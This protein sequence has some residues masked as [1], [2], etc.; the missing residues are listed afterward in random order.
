[1]A[2]NS[3][4]NVFKGI[5]SDREISNE[6]PNGLFGTNVYKTLESCWWSLLTIIQWTNTTP[7]ISRYFFTVFI[8]GYFIFSAPNHFIVSYVKSLRLYPLLILKRILFSIWFTYIFI[9]GLLIFYLCIYKC[10]QN[11]LEYLIQNMI[12]LVVQ[13]YHYLLEKI[14]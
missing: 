8:F 11:N 9:G 3:E 1:M 13:I 6:L 14:F 2:W 10:A 7:V 5:K 12:H 4:L